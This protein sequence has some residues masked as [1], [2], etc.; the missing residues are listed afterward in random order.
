MNK[1][2]VIVVGILALTLGVTSCGNGFIS[3]DTSAPESGQPVAKLSIFHEGCSK[4]E[5][6]ELE[7][8]HLEIYRPVLVDICSNF[9][10]DY[11]LVNVVA[12]ERVNQSSVDLYV[13]H[14][15]FGLSYWNRYVKGGMPPLE[16]ILLMEDEQQWWT[17]Q[18]EGKLT[19]E[20]EWFGPTDGGGHCYA[21]EAE[22]FCP[23]GYYSM[24][25]ETTGVNNIFTTM[26]G[27]RLEWTT[28][29]K[30][31]PIHESTHQFQSITGLGHW[32]YWYV[33]GQATYFELASSVLVSGLGA[34]DWRDE[35]ASLTMSQ[36]ELKFSADTADE[37]Y[38][39]MQKCSFGGSC[40]GFKYFGASLAHELLVNSYGIDKYID[41]NLAL[42]ER[43]PDFTWRNMPDETMQ[44]GLREFDA[45]FEEFFGIDIDQ[46]ER[47][48]LSP[49]ILK[50]YQ[51]EV[52]KTVCS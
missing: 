23:K 51:C 12:S 17:S 40:Q 33:E 18:L 36:D 34:S 42:A 47:D 31:T 38:D 15:V 6:G 29:R 9:E 32:R 41:W 21:A 50:T 30:V 46:W 14:N 48:E 43:L 4:L 2:T 37:T 22:A 5:S 7:H 8:K 20:P 19:L 11:G 25:S 35:Q 1:Q 28:F 49:Y 27:S 24:D 13:D 3:T 39:H 52:F 26:L 16:M 10:M 44:Q 45:I